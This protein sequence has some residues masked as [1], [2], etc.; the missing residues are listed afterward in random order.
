[1]NVVSLTQWIKKGSCSREWYGAPVGEGIAGRKRKKLLDPVNP[2]TLSY[3]MIQSA[4]KEYAKL[5]LGD[6]QFVTV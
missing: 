5:F 6:R 4:K 3:T 1:M 2:T